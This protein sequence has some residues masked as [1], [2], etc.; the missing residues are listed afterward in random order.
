MARWMLASPPR[1]TMRC[2][3]N[4][5]NGSPAMSCV[6]QN[7]AAGECGKKRWLLC[8]DSMSQMNVELTGYDG[9]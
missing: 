5:P 7:N 1:K 6:L 3:N 2:L 9:R 4:N 8:I